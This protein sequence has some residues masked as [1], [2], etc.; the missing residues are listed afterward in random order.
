MRV[1]RAHIVVLVFFAFLCFN[2]QAQDFKK[3][4]VDAE[5][6]FMYEDYDLALPLYLELY[7]RDTTNANLAYRI[8]ICYIYQKTPAEKK[9]AIPYLEFAVNHVSKKYKEGSYLE[10]N[11]PPDAWFYLGTAYRDNMDFEKAIAAFKKFTQTV[12]VGN[13]YYIDYVKRE[14]QCTE[15]AKQITKNPI[16][17]EPQNLSEVINAPDEIQNCPVVSDD[18]TIIVFTA[19]KKN[20]FS[21]ELDLN[22]TNIDYKLD[23]IYFSKKVDG[24]W[25]DPVNITKQLGAG[26]QQRTVPVSISAD[27]T[28]LYLV[29]DDNDDG[30]IYVSYLKN[31][32]WTK[33]KPLNKNINTKYW[34]SHATITKDGNTLFFTSDRPGGFGGLDIYRSDKDEKGEW[35][36]A[37]NLG[38]TINSI[39]DE[40]TP[41][42]VGQK[43][44]YTLYFSSQGHYSMGGFDV[45]YSNLLKNGKWST[46]I[47]IGYPLNTVGNDLFYVPKA[48]GE[49]FFFPLNNN[50]RGGIAKN[51][52]YKAKVSLPNMKPIEEKKPPIMVKVTLLGNI[53]LADNSPELPRD[54]AIMIVDTTKNKIIE[55]IIPNRDSATFRS[56]LQPGNYKLTCS[57]SGYNTHSEYIFV[58]ENFS[59]KEIVVDI[60]LQPVEVTKG[61]YY[62]IRSIFFDYGKYDLRRESEIELQRLAQLMQKNPGLMVEIVGHTDAMGS[63]KF[64]Q[65]LSENR[66]KAAIDYLVS[67]G[68]EPTRFVA[69]GMGK[70]QFIAINQ[71]PDGSDNPE[72]RQ[73][74]RRVEIKL[75]NTV[76]ENVIVEEIKVP[77]HLRFR[78]D[79]KVRDEN[80]YTVLLLQQKEKELG[81]QQLNKLLSLTQLLKEDSLFKNSSSPIKDNKIGDM[82]VFNAGE[83]KN[84]S[85]AMRI[86]NIVID[87]GF[88]DATIISTDELTKIKSEITRYIQK[89]AEQE[90][91]NVKK[92]Y[93]IQVRAYTTPV[94]LSTFKN[95]K[96][97]EEHY[98][99]DGFYRYTYGKYKTRA[100][101]LKEKERITELG[102]PDAFVVDLEKFKER[103]VE[104][105]EFTIQLKSSATPIKLA[106]FQ[107]LKENVQEVIGNDG[108]FKYIYG[109]FKSINEAKKDLEKVK[110]EGYTDAFIVN[111]SVYK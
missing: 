46:P 71:N 36:P 43:G 104:K 23:D 10:K 109:T 101:A 14:I 80:V 103:I 93:T 15:N 21:A 61:E 105:T 40:E 92:D 75:L 89:Q 95:L 57:A 66:A 49:Y 48:N 16:E 4:F 39:Y 100:E 37:V 19:G 59:Q 11:A 8:G 9:K 90:D 96:G 17:I 98:C 7:Q 3:K 18:E 58:P 52:I 13:V 70:R 41:F 24:K 12:P 85:D 91:L 27:G 44:N 26:S 76:P 33:M 51:N 42:V 110:R 77:Q 6:H 111:K 82:L 97:V 34:E 38:P 20:I 102:Y 63:D 50:E 107:K 65:K 108:N 99:N 74:N 56:I 73:L 60:M 78:K 87:Q 69:K 25:T 32:K 79:A 72:G 106:S 62:V 94:S 54:I 22:L 30:N 28:E 88:A 45:F 64:N 81:V 83:F 67:L 5:Y 2:I 86:L 47:N 35:G 84:K 29:R 53:R 55:N 1:L 68:I 31:D